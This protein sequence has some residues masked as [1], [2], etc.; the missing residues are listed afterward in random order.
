MF[1]LIGENMT[2]EEILQRIAF[3]LWNNAQ[4][5]DEAEKHCNME[6]VDP[7]AYM[8]QLEDYKVKDKPGIIK[9]D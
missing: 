6:G 4:L 1:G 3:L 8:K 5:T 2:N 9:T 7:H